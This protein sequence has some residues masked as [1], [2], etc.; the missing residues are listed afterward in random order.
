MKSFIGWQKTLRKIVA[1]F[2]RV[3]SGWRF[4]VEKSSL[5]LIFKNRNSGAIVG[6]LRF[7]WFWQWVGPLPLLLPHRSVGPSCKIMVNRCNSLWIDTVYKTLEI[8]DCINLIKEWS[9]MRL[10]D[11][12]ITQEQNLY[13]IFLP[14]GLEVARV[15]LPPNNQYAEHWMA[16]QMICKPLSKIWRINGRNTPQK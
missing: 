13:R 5:L 2:A 14:T 12:Y 8:L 10:S 6:E 4:T 1:F 7:K 15:A 16:L 11:L 9:S 3:A